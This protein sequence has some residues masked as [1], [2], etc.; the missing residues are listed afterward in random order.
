MIDCTKD[1][2]KAFLQLLKGNAKYKHIIASAKE[3]QEVVDV[4]N[5]LGLKYTTNQINFVKEKQW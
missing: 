1:S 2:E 4:I 5:D 3:W